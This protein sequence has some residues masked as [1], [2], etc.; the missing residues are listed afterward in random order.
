M[1]T[2]KGMTKAR[3]G[4]NRLKKGA[5]V[6]LVVLS[7]YIVGQ[8]VTV[9]QTRYQLVSPLIPERTI[10]DINKQ[11]IFKAL[12]ASVMFLIA[13]I[14]YFFERHLLVIILAAITLIAGRFIYI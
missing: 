6:C 14:L 5:K 2:E 12:V 9:Y 11:F 10:W 8:L 1:E 7:L 4:K 3:A 13:L